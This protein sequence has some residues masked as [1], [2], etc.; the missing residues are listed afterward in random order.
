M[1][2]GL[3]NTPKEGVE[4]MAFIKTI[5]TKDATG[6]LAEDYAYI[7]G[8]YSKKFETRTPTPQVYRTSSVVPEYFHF[9][10]LQNRVLT[11]DGQHTP[12]ESS[13]PPMLINFA[14]S[15]YSSC[16]Y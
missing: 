15:L 11:D 13:V 9:G 10:A 3:G 5:S 6:Q 8:S 2:V 14:V 4:D 12:V 1:S 7:S 16:F